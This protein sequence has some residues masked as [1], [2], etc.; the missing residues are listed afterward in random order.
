MDVSYDGEFDRYLYV[1]SMIK[2]SVLESYLWI[3][4]FL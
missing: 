1:V 2:I 3:M 4:F